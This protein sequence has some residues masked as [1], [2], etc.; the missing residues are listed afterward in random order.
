MNAQMRIL[1]TN[2]NMASE[3]VVLKIGGSFLLKDNQPDVL[4]LRQM[5]QVVR[6]LL[7]ASPRRRLVVVVGGGARRD[8]RNVFAL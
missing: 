2:R 6:E 4:E 1:I 7:A 5:A 8:C 3:V